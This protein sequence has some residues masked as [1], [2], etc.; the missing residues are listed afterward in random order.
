MDN[1]GV[2]LSLTSQNLVGAFKWS[3]TLNISHNS[4][5]V[6]DINGQIIESGD[7]LQRAVNG[8][9]IGTFYMQKFV[10]VDP[11]TGDALYDAGNG[12][13]TNDYDAAPRQALGSFVP[14]YTGGLTNTFS[15]KGVDLSIFFYGITG[16]KVFNAG[17][18]FQSDGFYN[19]FDNQTVD[20]LN[21]WKKPGDITM[22]PRIGYYNGSGYANSSRWLYKGDYLRLR[23]LT[24]G[25]SIPAA[26]ANGLGIKSA[27]IYVS[28]VNLLTFTKY[29]GDPE[30]NTNV[31][32]NIAGGEDFYTIPQAR[33]FTLGINVKF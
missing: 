32:N 18:R 15:Y 7:G 28:A 2:E 5:K 21:A 3:T 4:N 11:Q 20:I 16:N 9:P 19:G 30:V 23:N 10:G 8:E 31:V 12:K 24:L 17:G 25:Y 33:T 26:A 14:K 6:G 29:P 13:T 1:N 27:R 22:V